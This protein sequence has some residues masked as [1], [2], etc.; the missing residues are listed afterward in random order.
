VRIAVYLPLLIPLLAAVGAGPLSRR[1][2]PRL[3]TWLLTGA[4]ATLAACSG[5]A[6]A[7]LAATM[8]V[9]IPLLAVLGEYSVDVVYRHDP[10]TATVAVG[11]GV[12]LAI[13][14]AAA[15][16]LSW[17][18]AHAVL[19]AHR[20]A[21]CLPGITEVVVLADAT[22]DAFAVPGRP[23]RVVV[24]TAML[25][26]LDP[27]EQVALMAHE[28]AHLAC[29]HYLFLAVAHLAA[30]ANPLLRPVPAA[31]SYSVERWADEHA[32]THIGDRR[33]TARAI[34]KAALAIAG[35]PATRL[36]PALAADLA[37][38]V[39]DGSSL[40]GA[41]PVPRRVAALLTALPPARRLLLAATIAVVVASAAA[42][43][44]GQ[45]DLE[46]LLELARA[47][48]QQR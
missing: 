17:R 14:V 37:L 1:L 2:P 43:L 38:G 31:V 32:A 47:A 5:A 11:A 23:G 36:R 7:L 9:R 30:A 39:A 16:R 20:H 10:A 44:E 15:V 26:A 21:R 29:R 42:V 19:A 4:A 25:D 35:T 8:I 28:R 41:G 12:L 27:A 24:S 33:V 18:R 45:H 34:G 3:A 22:P 48:T 6:L 46:S 40:A 13:A